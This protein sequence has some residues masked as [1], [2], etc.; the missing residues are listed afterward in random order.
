MNQEE[1]RQARIILDEL[2]VLA[3]T[4][5]ADGEIDFLNRQWCRYTG[6]AEAESMSWG[7]ASALHPEDRDAVLARWRAALADG[8]PVELEV[9]LRRADGE[10]R[11]HLARARALKD[12]AGQVVGWCGTSTDIDERRRAHEAIRESEQAAR[13]VIDSIPGHVATTTPAGELEFANRQFLGYS[14]ESL[15]ERRAWRT[16][17][18][19]HPDDRPRIIAEWRHNLAAGEPCEMEVRLRRADGVYRW[20][21][22]WA[23]PTR[24]AK[25]RIE[26]W[27]LL[28]T[29]VDDLKRAQESLRQ[30]E[31]R[32]GQA[33]R[34]AALSELSASIAHEINQP[35][36]AVIANDH[37]CRRWLTSEPP[38][39]ERALVSIDRI[40]RDGHA[41][42]E[43]VRRM[44]SLFR[45]AEPVR[46]PLDI[47]RVVKDVLGLVRD[48]LQGRG[49]V[50]QTDLTPGLPQT[51]ADRVQI[52]QVLVNLARNGVEAMEAVAGRPRVLAV[53]TAL[54]DREVIV[55]VSD[56]G[57][58]IAAEDLGIVFESFYTTKATGMGMGLTI[59]RSIVEAHGGRLWATRN[60]THGT[61]FSFSLP[62]QSKTTA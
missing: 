17:D 46:E 37:A 34:L 32:L 53:A 19:A 55:A 41:A 54:R 52:Q 23:R 6:L 43:V 35:L 5:H 56:Q 42:A 11:W 13:L 44:Q 30:T 25:G 33:A 7:W 36:A 1:R 15:E 10:F 18:A 4:A 2:P 45:R 61:T 21:H 40:I 58:G 50:W 27:Y 48:E 24:D 39:I 51:Q 9:R 14:G 29:D 47:N 3:W 59:C 31:V 49:V 16:S 28:A 22:Y 20:F 38:N 57:V 8:A 12:A 26:R 62:L 60:E